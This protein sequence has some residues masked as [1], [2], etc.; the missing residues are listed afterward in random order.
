MYFTLFELSE[1]FS[2]HLAFLLNSNVSGIWE[3]FLN[4]LFHR[5]FEIPEQIG[6]IFSFKDSRDKSCP[7]SVKLYHSFH[8][9]RS[10]LKNAW[11]SLWI[12]RSF[13]PSRFE[14]L[15]N[16]NERRV[17]LAIGDDETSV[18]ISFP[19]EDRRDICKRTNTAKIQVH[20]H[21]TRISTWLDSR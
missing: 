3:E 7:Q 18:T 5:V 13:E 15:D 19:L 4:Q 12:K 9:G 6:P 11:V 2:F 16:W 17:R 8:Y 10:I 14:S 20:R 21:I 1:L